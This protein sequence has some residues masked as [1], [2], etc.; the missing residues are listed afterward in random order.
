[1][2]DDPRSDAELLDAFRRGDAAAF[3][4]LYHRHRAF[5]MRVALRFGGADHDEALD[6]LQDTFAWLIDRAPGLALRHRLS[7]LLYPV[8]KHLA[9]DRRRRRARAPQPLDATTEPAVLP[10]FPADV[11]AWFADLGE[12]QQEVLGLRFADGLSLEEIATAL[13]VPLG[14]VKSRLHHALR[15]LREKLAAE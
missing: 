10:G 1:M 3:A 15:Q 7:T 2:A 4:A 5:V 11:R 13:G 6:V 9:A 12:L 8:A 14:T